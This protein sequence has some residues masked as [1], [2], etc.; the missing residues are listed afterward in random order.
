MIQGLTTWWMRIDLHS[1]PWKAMLQ[2]EEVASG[3]IR[4]RRF[5]NLDDKHECPLFL[6]TARTSFKQQNKRALTLTI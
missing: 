2:N 5:L 3:S 4:E 1:H 6:T